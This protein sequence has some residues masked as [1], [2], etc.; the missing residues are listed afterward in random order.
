[1]L[2]Q[3]QS[4]KYIEQSGVNCPHCNSS[5]IEGGSMDMNAGNI[6][7]NI[8]CNDCQDMVAP[9]AAWGTEPKRSTIGKKE[10]RHRTK[11]KKQ[12]RRTR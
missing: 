11:T 5:N 6:Y 8:W 7:Q 10:R 12:N 9:I 3:E 2:T 1:M 4:R